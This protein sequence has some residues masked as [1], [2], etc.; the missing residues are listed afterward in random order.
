MQQ[1]MSLEPGQAQLKEE[2]N[3]E[4]KGAQGEGVE[5]KAQRILTADKQGDR[6][7]C[8]QCHARAAQ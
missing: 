6:Y 1:E 8:R 4:Q 3:L 5:R 7:S 2:E